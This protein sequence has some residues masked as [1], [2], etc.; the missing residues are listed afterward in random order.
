MIHWPSGTQQVLTASGGRSAAH[1]HRASTL[2]HRHPSAGAS[3]SRNF[4]HAELLH[5]CGSE[6]A[7]GA[8]IRAISSRFSSRS[9]WSWHSSATTSSA[10][11]SRLAVALLTCMATEALLSWFVRGKVVNLQSAYISGISLT[12]LVKPQGGALWPFAFGGFAGDRVQVRPAVPRQSSLESDELR[13]RHA[14][15]G[16]ARSHLGAEPSV[17]QRPRDESRDLDVRAGD[18][19]ARARRPHHAHVRRQLPRAEHSA[20]L[21]LGQPVL[22]EI[23]PI[24]GP[25][26]QLFVFFMITDPRTIVRDRRWQI[27]VAIIIAFV[28]TVIRF[29]SDQGWPLPTAFN[30]APGVRG[31]VDRRP[32]REV[33]RSASRRS[34]N[35]G[36]GAIP[37][38]RRQR[39]HHLIARHA[40]Q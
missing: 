19:H 6:T 3:A 12:L 21:V 36:S 15:A 33:D 9:C 31:A 26:Y 17:G 10:D 29:A 4:S 20:R 7:L 25:M 2:T 8:S 1:G 14:A 27:V 38:K 24:T 30:A 5:R 35:T 18:R 37:R 28:E 34:A 11:T 16:R 23:A 22:P 39:R 13:D 40:E 32:D